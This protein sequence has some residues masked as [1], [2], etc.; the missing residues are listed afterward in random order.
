MIEMDN[1]VPTPERLAAELKKHLICDDDHYIQQLC[2]AVWMQ[3]LKYAHF[4]LSSEEDEDSLAMNTLIIGPTGSGKT[5]AVKILAKLIELPIVVQNASMLTGEGFKG[6]NN[7]SSLVMRAIEAA[8]GDEYTAQY[9]I[10]VLDEWDKLVA[11]QASE[12]SDYPISNLLTFI[13][14]SVV[15]YSDRSNK[16]AVTLDTSHML[17]IF[18]G[19]FPGL[20]KIICKRLS[21]KSGI[22]FG[23]EGYVEP[24][25]KNIFKHVT[26][27]DLHEYGMSWEVLGRTTLISFTEE[28]TPENL[29]KILTESLSSPVKRYDEFLYKTLHVHVSITDTAACLVAEKALGYHTGARALEQVI[30]EIMYP[31]V[32]V[33]GSDD[34]IDSVTIDCTNNG[35]VAKYTYNG[36]PGL[37]YRGQGD[38]YKLSDIEHDIL[39]SV[40]FSCMRRRG[41][42]LTYVSE[43]QKSYKNRSALPESQAAAA[44]CIL[45]TAICSH[46]IATRDEKTTFIHLYKAIDVMA[47]DGMPA[48]AEIEDS[49]VY[50]QQL[51]EEI[52]MEF[53]NKAREYA[54]GDDNFADAKKTATCMLLDY[55][56]AYLTQIE[57]GA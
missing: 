3:F 5:H 15:S 43:I 34:S 33:L 12:T 27:Q 56:K 55:C 36:R 11:A 21:G 6:G 20:D 49:M 14:G 19:S 2:V 41:D 8:G 22:G 18:L 57:K 45:A 10:I 30:S 39:D 25:K 46:L 16:P 54:P 23:A 13:G 17:F 1:S 26:K 4:A 24:P 35:L 28:L 9:A 44:N 31:A 38:I 47:A 37:E 29:K 53:L 42:I 51:L 32:F 52:R 48:V 50:R 7:V 40:P